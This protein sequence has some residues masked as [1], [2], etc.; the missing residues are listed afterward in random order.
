MPVRTGVVALLL[1]LSGFCALIYQTTWLREFRLIFGGSTAATA[2]VLA[3]F[4]GGLGL[5]G[6]LLGRRADRSL[7][8]LALYGRLEAGI[9]ATAAIS[10]FLLLLARNVYIW[11][12]G[13]MAFGPL[14]ASGV[15]VLLAALVIG[16]PTVLMGG[17]LPAAA[18]AI[19]SSEDRGRRRLAV[20]YGFNTLGAVTGAVAATFGMLEHLG[21]RK[22]LWT[23]AVLNVLVALAALAIAAGRREPVEEIA[24]ETGTAVGARISR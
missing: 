14:L 4:M 3:I 7:N 15:R 2:A 12:G 19:E 18:R 1:F 24:E 6:A 8:P 9:A 23:A 22:T 10:P 11:S 21:N 20:L 5:G 16:L 13:S 17:T